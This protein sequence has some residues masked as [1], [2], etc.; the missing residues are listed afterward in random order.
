MVPHGRK[1]PPGAILRYDGRLTTPSACL[2]IVKGLTVFPSVCTAICCATRYNCS[3]ETANM[4]H[5]GLW[6]YERA[7]FR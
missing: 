3:E 7:K 5:F 6:F 2:R 4:I 1:E